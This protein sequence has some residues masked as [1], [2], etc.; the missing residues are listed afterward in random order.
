MSGSIFDIAAFLQLHLNRGMVN[1]RQIVLPS[2]LDAC[3]RRYTDL[4]KGVRVGMD[5]RDRD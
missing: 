1:G 5:P 2:A 3:Y 4:G